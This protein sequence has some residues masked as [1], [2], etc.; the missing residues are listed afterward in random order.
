MK[1]RAAVA[2]DSMGV[3]FI[4]NCNR[5]AMALITDCMA[6]TWYKTS[7]KALKKTTVGKI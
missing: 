4:A 3:V 6:P 1:I 7:I 2:N 5:A